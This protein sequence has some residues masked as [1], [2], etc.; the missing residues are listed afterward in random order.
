MTNL[1]IGEILV[2][3]II[4]AVP[5][6]TSGLIATFVKKRSFLGWFSIGL[7][8]TLAGGT[9]GALLGVLT[10]VNA[11]LFFG[12]ISWVIAPILALLLPKKAGNSAG[13]PPK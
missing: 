4:A 12:C 6:L 8:I 7:G 3:V 11:T 9:F 13:E 2:F 10:R 1:G 5:S